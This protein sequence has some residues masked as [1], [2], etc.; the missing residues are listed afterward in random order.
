MLT[1]KN[2]E[3]YLTFLFDYSRK[4]S[5]ILTSPIKGTKPRIG[6]IHPGQ[7]GLG[8]WLT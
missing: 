5:T 7:G 4:W 2:P 8:R 6:R 1:M 3:S